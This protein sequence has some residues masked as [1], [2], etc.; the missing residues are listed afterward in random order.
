MNPTVNVGDELAF[1]WRGRRYEIHKVEKVSKT[2]RIT[3]RGFVLDPNLRIRGDFSW[4][5]PSICLATDEHR[6]KA[7][8]QRAVEELK[9]IRW[10]SLSLATLSEVL[11][12]VN[13]QKGGAK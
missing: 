4:D 10:E 6:E 9:A 1:V 11:C 12:L 8:H 7:G 3:V 5:H 13:G 2:G